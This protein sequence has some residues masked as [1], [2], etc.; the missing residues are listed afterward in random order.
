MVGPNPHLPA[1][2]QPREWLHGRGHHG[3]SILR[4][5]M[6]HTFHTFHTKRRFL[7]HSPRPDRSQAAEAGHTK[8]KHSTL[9]V[10]GFV[11][12]PPEIPLNDSTDL[13]LT[14]IGPKVQMGK[15]KQAACT[16]TCWGHSSMSRGGIQGNSYAGLGAEAAENLR[17]VLSPAAPP[18]PPPALLLLHFWGNGDLCSDLVLVSGENVM[19]AWR[20]PA[21]QWVCIRQ[22]PATRRCCIRQHMPERVVNVFLPLC[23]LLHLTGLN[24]PPPPESPSAAVAAG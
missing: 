20:Y 5:A 10:P 2:T 12:H 16:R 8:T 1:T 13:S 22:L 23:L 14:P 18:P 21:G 6:G 15:P 9:I 3:G 4:R 11:E 24:S 19:H 17:L 7:L